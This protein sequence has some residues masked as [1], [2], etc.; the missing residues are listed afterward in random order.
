MKHIFKS[1]SILLLLSCS[2]GSQP[3]NYGKDNCE[4]CKMTIMD[5]KF[6][7][8]IITKKGKAFKFDSDECLRSYYNAASNTSEFA[9]VFVTDYQNPGN[10]V[11]GKLAFY[12]HGLKVKSPMGGNLAAFGKKADAEKMKTQWAAEI[13]TWE[14][15]L[16]IQ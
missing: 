10:L 14:Q 5:P 11:D 15:M 12:L 3:I 7:T 13:L 2:S 1:A 8:E 6:G 9:S 16:K 4:F